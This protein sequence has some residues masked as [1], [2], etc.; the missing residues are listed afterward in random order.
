LRGG[1]QSGNDADDL[2][3]GNERSSQQGKF[4]VDDMQIR[5]AHTT[6]VHPE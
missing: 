1:A 4:A 6:G 2:V 3:A 5:A